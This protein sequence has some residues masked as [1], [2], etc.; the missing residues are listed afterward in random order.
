[1]VW[2]FVYKKRQTVHLA[3]LGKQDK[4]FVIKINDVCRAVFLYY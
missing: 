3:N 1:M 4:T 2:E